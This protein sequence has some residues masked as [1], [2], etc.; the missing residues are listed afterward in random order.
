MTIIL[1]ILRSIVTVTIFITIALAHIVHGQLTK[2]IDETDKRTWIIS[3][4]QKSDEEQNKRLE[5][6][7][8]LVIDIWKATVNK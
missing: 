5:K 7:D 1:W 4:L 2:L 8:R 3:G 6:I